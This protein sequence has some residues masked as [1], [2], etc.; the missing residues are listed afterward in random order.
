MKKTNLKKFI[1]KEIADF[2]EYKPVPSAWD[3]KREQKKKFADLIK[4]D[5]GE[6]TYGPSPKVKKVLTAF[7][8]YQFY[9]DPQYKELRQMLS[10][11][12][13]APPDSIVVGN[14][15]DEI[16]DLLTRL[17]LS[18]GDAVINSPP[19]FSSYQLSTVLSYGKIITVPRDKKFEIDVKK[20][21]KALNKKTK[22]IF[23]CNPNNP[24]GNITPADEVEKLLDL[25]VLVVVDEAY[26]EFSGQT[27][28]PLLKKYDNL[29][30]IR[31]FSK[32]AG[33]AGLRLGYALLNPYLATQL[34]KIKSPYNVNTAAE[35]AARAALADISFYKK[36]N[37]LIIA[38]RERVYKVVSKFP[39][40]KVWP[41]GG[42]YLY[43]EIQTNKMKKLKDDCAKAGVS[44]RY[45][46][47]AVRLTIGR[48]ELNDSALNIFKNL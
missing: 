1:R 4:L 17:I 45:Y 47:N 6:N 29:I 19:T 42:N 36:I 15:G 34:S 3:L 11:Y 14:G 48:P 22:M 46:K 27:V 2:E 38:E 37:S 40:I 26:F 25:D 13:G 9:P 12:T 33:I 21:K 7:D 24:T 8:G 31:S 20:I 28:A 32:W 30:I 10:D 41:S 43:I 18:P 44:L 16:I 39:T 23:V 5:A 35:V